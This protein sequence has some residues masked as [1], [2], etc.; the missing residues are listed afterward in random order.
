MGTDAV[1]EAGSEVIDQAR[2]PSDVRGR[3]A[4]GRT[5]PLRRE[6]SWD[7]YEEWTL[8]MT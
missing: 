5:R 6:P 4:P 7:W 8:V 1:R 3:R 2:V